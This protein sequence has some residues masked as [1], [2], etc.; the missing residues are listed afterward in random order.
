MFNISSYIPHSVLPTYEAFKGT[1]VSYLEML[2]IV[3][4]ATEGSTTGT[5]TYPLRKNESNVLLPILPS[6]HRPW[7]A[8]PTMMLNT[9]SNS[10]EKKN[11]ER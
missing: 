8:K 7:P 2:G 3:R 11:N 6:Q 9:A 5:V 10:Q 4:G 1:I